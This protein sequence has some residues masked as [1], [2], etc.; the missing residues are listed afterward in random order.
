[1]LIETVFLMIAALPQTTATPSNTSFCN[2]TWSSG[3]DGLGG[4]AQIETDK[5]NRQVASRLTVWTQDLTVVW[6]GDPK[7]TNVSGS[8]ASLT[9]N[10]LP[11]PK[12]IVFPVR[13]EVLVDGTS[14]GRF[15]FTEAGEQIVDLDKYREAQRLDQDALLVATRPGVQ[16]PTIELDTLWGTAVLTVVATDR[17]GGR[18]N[19]TALL[20]PNWEHVANFAETAFPALERNRVAGECRPVYRVVAIN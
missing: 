20:L 9:F 19:V 5:A 8:P 1:M 3:Q 7:K 11:L 4:F 15:S 2:Q 17:H 6:S 16:I 14:A 13:V 10:S 12:D 18:A